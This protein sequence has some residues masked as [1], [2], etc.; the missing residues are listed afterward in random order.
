MTISWSEFKLTQMGS[1]LRHG[2]PN[3]LLLL[4][5]QHSTAQ[6]PDT[7][8]PTSERKNENLLSSLS[9]NNFTGFYYGTGE[10]YS[11]CANLNANQGS[12]CV[13]YSDGMQ[14]LDLAWCAMC[15]VQALIVFVSF[16]FLIFIFIVNHIQWVAQCFIHSTLTSYCHSSRYFWFVCLFY[17]IVRIAHLTNCIDIHIFCPQSTVKGL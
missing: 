15:N 12:V 6:H 3:V 2:K 4:L 5:F 8:Q 10:I 13:R 14:G 7:H 16:L 17:L 1:E 9:T 11:R